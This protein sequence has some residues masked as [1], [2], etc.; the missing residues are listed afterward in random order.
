MDLE[1]EMLMLRVQNGVHW[2]TFLG[3]DGPRK[4]GITREKG[5]FAVCMQASSAE[6]WKS[7]FRNVLFL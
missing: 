4:L 1:I 2:D 5:M 7:I 3:V 6:Y